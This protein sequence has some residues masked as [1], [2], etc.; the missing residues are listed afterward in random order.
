MLD[1]NA[2]HRNAGLSGVSEASRHAAVGG[3]S[4]VGITVDNDSR[5]PSQFENDFFLSSIV[6]DGPADGRAASK[7]DELDALIADEEAGVFVG[8]QDCV[9]PAVRPSRLLNDLGQQKGTERRLG[10]GLKHHGT[11]RG[12]RRSDFVRYQVQGKIKRSDASYWAKGETFDNA[13][14][15]G[16]GLLPIQRQIFSVAANRLFGGNVESKNSTVDFVASALDGLARF[17]RQRAGKFFSAIV[18]A[19]RNLAQNSLTLKGGQAA[20][21]PKSLDG[22]GNGGFRMFTAPLMDVRYEGAIVRRA[23]VDDVALFQPLPVQKKTVGCNRSHRHF[24]HCLPLSSARDDLRPAIDAQR[25]APDDYRTPRDGH[26]QLGKLSGLGL[27]LGNTNAAQ[28]LSG[29]R[30]PRPP[31]FAG[32][33]LEAVVDFHLVSRDQAIGFVRHADHRH[34]FFELS[35]GHAF[36]YR[37]GSVRSDAVFALVRDR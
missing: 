2:L 21:S 12:N 1:Q 24:S 17:Q 14:A 19:G 3:V 7:A 26:Y 28:L 8:E 18:N 31:S 35:V 13:P 29:D 25:F 30:A 32:L 16:G 11:T 23:H 4:Q 22:S 10:R 5:I 15:S 6:L 37:R 27:G 36:V 34:E 33:R 20:G 9:E